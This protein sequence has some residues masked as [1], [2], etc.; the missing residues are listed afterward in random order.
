[1]DSQRS[2]ADY[3]VG[4]ICALPVELAAAKAILDETHPRISRIDHG[5][6]TLG[7]LDGHNIVIA[8]LP[9]G[10]YGTSSASIVATQMLHAFPSIIFGLM[11]GIGGGVPS[12][13]ADIR[14]GDVV[15]S[16]PVGSFGGV[17]QYDYGKEVGN[18]K[19]KHTGSLN[20]P[21]PFLLSAIGDLEANHSIDFSEIPSY[22]SKML[23]RHPAMKKFRYP[24]SQSDTLYEAEY[25]H[26]DSRDGTCKR[27]S[28]R[29]SVYRPP[30][31][32]DGPVIHYGLIASG[33][34][35]MRDGVTRD[36]IADE[37]GGDVICF[38]MEAAGLMDI[39]PCI[40]IRGICD[41]ADSHKNKSWQPYAAAT[42]AAYAKE[43]LSVVPARH[44]LEKTLQMGLSSDE[45]TPMKREA[46]S[47][48]SRRQ[49]FDDGS[50]GSRNHPYR[51]SLFT[52]IHSL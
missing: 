21:P 18:G 48:N 33:N 44:K 6:Y 11:V 8:C 42:A 46:S 10:V 28:K 4:W 7:A 31:S 41:Y 23:R 19:V 9:A 2:I 27:C 35:V 50:L 38:E 15:V 43:L 16:R 3:T 47:K 14:L 5:I 1:M 37:L 34:K 36:H 12:E 49:S 22:L 40:V 17:V 32:S 29:H 51:V 13:R 20:K 52:S 39:F 45:F 26:I 25:Y 24:G 30:R